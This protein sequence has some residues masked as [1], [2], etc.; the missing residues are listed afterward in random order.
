MIDLKDEPM[1]SQLVRMIN[2]YAM[3]DGGAWEMAI[4]LICE[5]LKICDPWGRLRSGR[6]DLRRWTR[7]SPGQE[8]TASEIRHGPTLHLPRHALCHLILAP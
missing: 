7:H 6:P 2:G 5:S 3:Y 1:D 8:L 4:S